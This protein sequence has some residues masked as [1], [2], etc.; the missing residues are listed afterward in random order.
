MVVHRSEDCQRYQQG[1]RNSRKYGR[2]V[3][4]IE[5]TTTGDARSR[6]KHP[7]TCWASSGVLMERETWTRP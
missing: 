5:W 3:W 4:P 7:C 2:K 1:I 6:D